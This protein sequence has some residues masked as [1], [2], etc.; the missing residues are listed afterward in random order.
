[1]PDLKKLENRMHELIDEYSARER[2]Y[3]NEIIDL[4][5]Q[6]RKL[7]E[8]GVEQQMEMGKLYSM[9]KFYSFEW[10]NYKRDECG[11]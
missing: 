4:K 7:Q 1:M 5:Y 10:V 8:T 2:K 3:V 11:E 9:G 6:L